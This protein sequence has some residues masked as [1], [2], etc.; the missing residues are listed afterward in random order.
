MKVWEVF[1]AF[2]RQVKKMLYLQGEIAEN[3]CMWCKNR[4][5]IV[6]IRGM[7]I[8]SRAQTVNKAVHVCHI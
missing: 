3:T 8:G 5:I 6:L 2:L 7:E 1:D 4:E